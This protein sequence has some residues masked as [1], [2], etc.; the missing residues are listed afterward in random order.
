[1]YLLY[2]MHLF[3]VNNI[4]IQKIFKTKIFAIINLMYFILINIS[5]LLFSFFANIINKIF[6]L[7][8]KILLK[9]KI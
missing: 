3:N 8:I 7:M 4:Y 9:Q 5:T 1:M 6:I 2:L